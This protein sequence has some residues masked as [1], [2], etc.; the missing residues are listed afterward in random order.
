[1]QKRW[2][3]VLLLLTSAASGLC[4]LFSHPHLQTPSLKNVLDNYSNITQKTLGKE[5]QYMDL[6]I[7]KCLLKKKHMTY[8]AYIRTVTQCSFK[9]K[10]YCIDTYRQLSPELDNGQE[11]SSSFRTICGRFI[12]NLRDVLTNMSKVIQTIHVID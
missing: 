6:E 2:C 10:R 1:M 4:Q 8:F 5:V 12:F 11:Q 7:S 3:F 9:M